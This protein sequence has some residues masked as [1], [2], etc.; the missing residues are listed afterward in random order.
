M[1]LSVEDK[2]AEK[3]VNKKIT[4]M[5]AQGKQIHGVPKGETLFIL[6]NLKSKNKKNK[7]GVLTF[8]DSGCSDAVFR[9]GVPEKD[10]FDTVQ[11]DKRELQIGTAGNGSIIA[12]G[13]YSTFI[14]KTDGSLQ[15][16][17]GPCLDELTDIF[18]RINTEK[19]VTEMK[20]S[21]KSYKKLQDCVVPKKNRRERC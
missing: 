7:D 4:S 2:K 17:R 12:K 13:Q 6:A 18:P 1:S 8:F 15:N 16:I 11:V 5:K 3:I 20:D 21:N 14:Q 9:T 10:F 19:A